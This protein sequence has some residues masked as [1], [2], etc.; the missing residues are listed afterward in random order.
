MLADQDRIFIRIFPP[1]GRG[2]AASRVSG[3][4]GGGHRYAARDPH[5]DRLAAL[6]ERPS[7]L[8]GEGGLLAES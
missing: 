5:P 6:G 3:E 8:Q 2:R 4:P 1:S 7:P